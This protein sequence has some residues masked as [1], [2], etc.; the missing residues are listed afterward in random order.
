[1]ERKEVPWPM[2]LRPGTVPRRFRQP[3]PLLAFLE[4][5]GLCRVAGFPIPAPPAFDLAHWNMGG[6]I[7]ESV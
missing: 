7:R 6:I 1:M 2:P 5:L 3:D 4:S